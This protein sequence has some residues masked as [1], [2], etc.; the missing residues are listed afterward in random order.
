[1]LKPVPVPGW[2]ALTQQAAAAVTGQGA[3]RHGQ[4]FYPCPE[5]LFA[6]VADQATR[7]P[8]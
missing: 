5:A 7:D 4:L 6:L 8:L 1:V 3:L 2:E